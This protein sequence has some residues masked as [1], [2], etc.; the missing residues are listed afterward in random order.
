M[1]VRMVALQRASLRWWWLSSGVV[2]AT[3]GAA[4][5]SSVV[6]SRSEGRRT[7]PDMGL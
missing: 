3:G 1:A 7:D 6:P 5:G 2:W 4:A